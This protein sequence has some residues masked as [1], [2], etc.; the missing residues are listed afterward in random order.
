M[1]CHKRK[2][3]QLSEYPSHWIVMI[4]ALKSQQ[5]SCSATVGLLVAVAA[6]KAA[7][8]PADLSLLRCPAEAEGRGRVQLVIQRPLDIYFSSL[9]LQWPRRPRVVTHSSNIGV[10][11]SGFAACASFSLTAVAP[12]RHRRSLISL[13]AYPPLSWVLFPSLTEII[14]WVKRSYDLESGNGWNHTHIDD[15]RLLSLLLTHNS[16]SIS[17]NPPMQSHTS[18][19]NAKHG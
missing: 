10:E 1:V 4:S 15:T 12:S 13:I 2:S 5:C 19:A 11:W 3:T 16:L 7:L 9:A 8:L 6:I 17:I 18:G 14:M